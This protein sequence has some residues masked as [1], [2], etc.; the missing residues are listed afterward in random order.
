MIRKI[1]FSALVLRLILAFW[2][3]HSDI[4]NYYWWSKHLLQ[5]GLN[6]F[7]DNNIV[8]AMRAT[9]PPITSY[10]FWLNAYMHEIIWKFAWLINSKISF[11]P[12]NFILWLES[13]KGWYYINKLPAILSDLGII[14][15]LFKLVVLIK[16]KK[17][18]LWATSI[19]AFL[20][21]FWYNSALWGQTDS[22]YALPLLLAFYF[23]I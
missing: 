18:A 15:V 23:L 21:P 10:I 11:F 20:P 22:I 17:S 6:G 14:Y 2:G 16:T 4:V 12:S 3:Q 5:Y 19:Y 8:N 1:V 7:Y 9:Y 13:A